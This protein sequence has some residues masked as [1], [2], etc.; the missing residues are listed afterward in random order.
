MEKV[1]K[2]G[3][4]VLPMIIFLAIF[5]QRILVQ[6]IE[7]ENDQIDAQTEMMQTVVGGEGWT[8]AEGWSVSSE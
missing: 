4:I 3:V 2:V 6:F 7:N 5:G 8:R 1:L